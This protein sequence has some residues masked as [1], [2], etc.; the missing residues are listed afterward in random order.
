MVLDLIVHR[1]DD[2][3]TA[4]VPSIKGCETW[5]PTEDEV[6]EKIEELTRYYLKRGE[7]KLVLDKARG[8]YDSSLYKIIVKS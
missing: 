5:A 2:G 6:L 8:G 3:F 1:T 4:E 7:K